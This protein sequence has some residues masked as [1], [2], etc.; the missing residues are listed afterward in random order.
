MNHTHHS[1]NTQLDR[2]SLALA[3]FQHY[4]EIKNYAQLHDNNR[5]AESLMAGL[6]SC[7]CGWGN[8]IDLNKEKRDHYAIDLLSEDGTIGVQVTAT[9]NTDRVKQTLEKF[10]SLPNKPQRLCLLMLC[11]RQKNYPS[12]SLNQSIERAGIPFDPKFDILD[13]KSLFRMAQNNDQAH[14]EAAV[15][16]LEKEMGPRALA[17]LSSYNKNADRV[18]Q[19]LHAHDLRRSE[20][21]ELLG[22]DP[23]QAPTDITTAHGLQPWLTPSLCN[24][25]AEQFNV[26]VDWL[27]GTDDR[28]GD[29]YNSSS[30]RTTGDVAGLLAKVAGR[31]GHAHFY[32]VIPD[33]L[34]NPFEHFDQTRQ[35]TWDVPFLVFYKARGTYGDVFAHLGVQPWNI[36]HHRQAALFLSTTLR[37]FSRQGFSHF[38]ITWEQWSRDDIMASCTDTLLAEL[39]QNR[40]GLPLDGQDCIHFD[41]RWQFPG[42]PAITAQFN[43]DYLPDVL[44][45]FNHQRQAERVYRFFEKRTETRLAWEN[46]ASPAHG[47]KRVD[48]NLACDIAQMCGS[49]V[50]CADSLGNE[51][52]LGVDQARKLIG[53]QLEM[54]ACDPEK[55]FIFLDIRVDPQKP[56]CST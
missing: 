42:Q 7:I 5:L 47:A 29:Y 39:M 9:R 48:G 22:I 54:R 3:V 25:I 49:P 52:E 43:D 17:M 28:I 19:V 33:D 20:F 46:I 55:R 1:R 51:R 13:L 12:E 38:S 36:L 35:G 41:G 24:S 40:T 34:D 4:I 2:L 32:I 50:R 10:A 8:F 15:Q 11:G 18:L 6:M 31:Y 44:R 56:K 26:S 53:E 14:I 21:N 23:R 45:G 37:D 16:Q 30:W 27:D